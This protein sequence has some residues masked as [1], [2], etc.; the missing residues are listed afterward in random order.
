MRMASRPRPAARKP[1]P[2]P[3]PSRRR[4]AATI[5]RGLRRDGP[6]NSFYPGQRPPGVAVAPESGADDLTRI[7]GIDAA[8]ERRLHG[9][10]IWTFAQIAAW[11][12]DQ[13]RWVE[14]YLAEPGRAG[15]ENWREQA[16]KLVHGAPAAP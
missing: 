7:A 1:R 16:G 4:L 11:T 8:A 15:R 2:A 12:A 6:S 14:F 3:P 5:C 13:T 9:L 10:G